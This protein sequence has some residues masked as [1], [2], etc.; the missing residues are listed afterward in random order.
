MQYYLGI[1][2]IVFQCTRKGHRKHEKYLL[3]KIDG[4]YSTEKNI[5]TCFLK[6]YIDKYIIDGED[7]YICRPAA[8]N[9]DTECFEIEFE[10]IVEFK[11]VNFVSAK[12]I[13][14]YLYKANL[15]DGMAQKIKYYFDHY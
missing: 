9:S 14:S 6:V 15:D 2:S 11:G 12:T 7:K 4:T 13:L 10:D 5:E 8:D 1:E 3:K